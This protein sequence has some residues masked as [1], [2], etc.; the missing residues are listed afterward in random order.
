MVRVSNCF[1]RVAS[2]KMLLRDNRRCSLPGWTARM[3]CLSSL[4]SAPP[5]TQRESNPARP[6]LNT[7]TYFGDP[8]E[9]TDGKAPQTL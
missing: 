8:K 4:L 2:A 5:A 3:D 7:A 1:R 9:T 6:P